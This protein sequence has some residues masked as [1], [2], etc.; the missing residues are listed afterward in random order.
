M[1]HCWGCPPGATFQSG[2]GRALAFHDLWNHQAPRMPMLCEIVYASLAG[3]VDGSLDPALDA[4]MTCHI[5]PRAE[6]GNCK[7]CLEALRQA[8]G[9]K[10]PR[11]EP[12]WISGLDS[13]P[14]TA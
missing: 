1:L 13:P 14:P 9:R 6:F 10:A 4:A 11:R 2:S 5:Q 3:F 7:F 8:I 12:L